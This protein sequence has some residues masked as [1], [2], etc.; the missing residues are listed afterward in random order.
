MYI[1]TRQQEQI[2]RIRSRA[3]FTYF[4]GEEA[5]EK[6]A[7]VER[8]EP[9]NQCKSLWALIPQM[10]LSQLAVQGWKATSSTRATLVSAVGLFPLNATSIEDGL[11]CN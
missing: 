2:H 4:V 11:V 9:G 5:R 7:E 3:R 10:H 8:T 1:T 6:E